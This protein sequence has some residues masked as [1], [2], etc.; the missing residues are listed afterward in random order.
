MTRRTFIKRMKDKDK[1]YISVVEDQD[2]A[3]SYRY[4]EALNKGYTINNKRRVIIGQ[5]SNG[6]IWGTE[7]IFEKKGKNED[8]KKTI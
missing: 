4:L 6:Y 1:K 3:H 8:T 2:L 5:N 7:Y